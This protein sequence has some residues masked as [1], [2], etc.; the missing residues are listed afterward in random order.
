MLGRMN[1]EG[2]LSYKIGAV[3]LAGLVIL[4]AAWHWGLPAYQHAKE[5]RHL[6]EAQGFFDKGDY[7]NALM[8]ARLV[9]M[10]D[11]N[12]VPA[13]RIMA[14][15]AEV[16][17][18]PTTLDWRQRLVELDPTAENKLALA[19]AALQ[20][21]NPPFP[22]TTQLLDQLA[23]VATN[24]VAY[25]SVAT[26][27]ALRLNRPA[28]AETHLAAAARLDPTNQSFPLNI[29]V[30]QLN[31]TNPAV[32]KAARGTLEKFQQD[33]NLG[34]AALRSLVSERLMREDFPSARDYSTQ[35]LAT[36]AVN[37]GDRLQ[38]L[39]ILKRLASP[40]LTAQL[41][42]V[43][44]DVATNAVSAAQTAA[45][46]EANGFVAEAATWLTALPA[47]IQSQ[48]VVQLALVDYYL[49]T[50]NWSG[51]CQFT[52]K[53]DWGEMDFLRLAFLS[54]SWE[55]LGE[56]LV[57]DSQ[58]NSAVNQAGDRLGAL[59]TLLGLAGRWGKTN[60][61]EQLLLRIAERYPDAVWAQQGLEQLYQSAGNTRK[62]N[63]FYAD[64]L[65]KSPQSIVFKNNLAAT[66][67]LLKT[68]LTEAAQLAAEIYAQQPAEPVFV[69]T[70][71]FALHLQGRDAE[72]L[73]ALQKL[74]LTQL[75]QPS[76]AFYYGLL[77]AATGDSRA[78]HFLAI[79][80]KDGHLLP[81]EKALL[82]TVGK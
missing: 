45:W 40:D 6:A 54:R 51:L 35:L 13:C 65:A 62:L 74:S 68:N 2:K 37:L 44:A 22:L 73:A 31:S 36:K 77:L 81:E 59:N 30:L 28:D 80:E 16:S 7:R 26:M 23:P 32:V 60:T 53:G 56:S 8:S 24:I 12:S 18:S 11:S 58:W 52:A 67:L 61:Q 71:A 57:A 75:E 70:Y 43:Q 39:S 33:P 21:Q 78:W 3:V 38:Y 46:M 82:A 76:V 17:H 66:E 63:Q 42:S 48:P 1:S 79:A 50:T 29:A 5:K 49:G 15:L 25:H 10:L 27:L 34:P 14:S 19:A 20:F 41:K 55:E 9:L 69:S 72:G 4:A 47:D 64:Q